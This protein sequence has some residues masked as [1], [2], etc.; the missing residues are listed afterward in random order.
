MLGRMLSPYEFGC[1]VIL[2]NLVTLLS[3]IGQFGTRSYVV[4]TLAS[5]EAAGKSEQMLP[6]ICKVAVVAMV[7]ST[8]SSLV[9]FIGAW[10]SVSGLL[11]IGISSSNRYIMVILVP[12]LALNLVLPE[13]FRGI[14]WTRVA[15]AVGPPIYNIL[16]A[17]VLA[18]VGVLFHGSVDLNYVFVTLLAS[19]GVSISVAAFITL[20]TPLWHWKSTEISLKRIVSASVPFLFTQL[21][22]FLMLNSDVWLIA[23]K[24]GPEE[25]GVYGAA[26]RLAL[27]VGIPA[28]IGIS[29]ILGRIA[30]LAA[31]NNNAGIENTAREAAFAFTIFGAAIAVPF[32]FYGNGT[33]TAVYGPAFGEGGLLLGI[34]ALGQLTTAIAGPAQ[35]V[36][37]MNG[38]ATAMMLLTL[39]VA[40]F[41]ILLG[42]V[43]G[44]SFGAVGV[45]LCYCAGL[46]SY[47]GMAVLLVRR[48][49]GIWTLPQRPRNIF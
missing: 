25:A 14:R 49:L 5:L 13:V 10:P 39:C 27:M 2:W 32:I 11:D 26:S 28:Q 35:S 22:T 21:G 20:A 34:L 18:T 19:A 23:G 41:N 37:M 38:G 47:A 24:L 31:V 9:V 42:Y 17:T 1:Y 4:K 15:N 16:F 12:A 45:A 8:A 36:M 46:A 6:L 30:Q 7:F 3:L 44:L 29:V 48:K 40:T 33:M 43:I